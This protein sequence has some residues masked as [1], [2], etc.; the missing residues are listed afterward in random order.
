MFL[1][2]FSLNTIKRRRI[3]CIASI[4]VWAVEVFSIPCYIIP[5]LG[6][7]YLW[8]ILQQNKNIL[9]QKFLYKINSNSSADKNYYWL[10]LLFFS[11]LKT[12]IINKLLNVKNQNSSSRRKGFYTTKWF[13]WFFY[14]CKKKVHNKYYLKK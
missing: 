9:I 10:A 14:L 3:R 13:Y 2:N 4:V 5:G 12:T 8:Q 6:L 7:H 11:Y 1:I